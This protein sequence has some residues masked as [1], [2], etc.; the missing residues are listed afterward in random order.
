MLLAWL[1]AKWF[2]YRLFSLR[3]LPLIIAGL[4][5]FSG[6]AWSV[7]TRRFALSRA[8]A[9]GEIG[10]LILG[11]GLAQYPYLVYPDLPFDSVAAPVATLRFVVLSLPVGAALIFPSLWMLFRVFKSNP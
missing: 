10:L 4:G 7:V 2:F 8:C 3:T 11:W 9:A 1:G 5:C 6:S